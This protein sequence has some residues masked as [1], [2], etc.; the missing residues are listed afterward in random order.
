MRDHPV[1]G[2]LLQLRTYLV[3]IWRQRFSI[4]GW[5]GAVAAGVACATMPALPVTCACI[6]CALLR[7]CRFAM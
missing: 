1:I 6:V 7:V 2:R 5:I 4:A 3:R